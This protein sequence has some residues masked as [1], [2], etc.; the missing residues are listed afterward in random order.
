MKYFNDMSA[1]QSKWLAT[2][3]GEDNNARDYYPP[4]PGL[5]KPELFD[6]EEQE[7]DYGPSGV[8]E[9][10]QHVPQAHGPQR[11]EVSNLAVYC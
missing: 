9:V 11:D 6:H 10:L 4:V 5:Q 2:L 7:D 3:E 1:C 8:L